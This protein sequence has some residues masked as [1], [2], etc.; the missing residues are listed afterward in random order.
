MWS[1]RADEGVGCGDR[2][3]GTFGALSC[4]CGD[5]QPAPTFN[6]GD[7]DT[8]A[9]GQQL[10]HVVEKFLTEHAAVI[11][12]IIGITENK[13]QIVDVKFT[14]A[15]SICHNLLGINDA[16]FLSNFPAR[17]ARKADC[18]AAN[19]TA[20]DLDFRNRS[21]RRRSQ[22]KCR[23]QYGGSLFV[24]SCR[25]G[26]VL[27]APRPSKPSLQFLRGASN[28]V[29]WKESFVWGP[30]THLETRK[31]NPLNRKIVHRPVFFSRSPFAWGC[32]GVVQKCFYGT[33][34][35]VGYE[36]DHA[37]GHSP[38]E[39]LLTDR[40]SPEY[41]RVLRQQGRAWRRKTVIR[42]LVEGCRPKPALLAIG[43]V[44]P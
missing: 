17:V 14:N 9:F 19:P 12:I 15:T 31:G 30:E 13:T 25:E 35:R 29:P 26:V 18:S 21:S 27:S 8:G 40:T 16:E 1:S 34:S 24:R 33:S 5:V 44:Q 3:L 2:P 28:F 11:T 32:R 42:D 38:K 22:E 10:K 23:A 20:R 6:T 7:G 4:D 39:D 36:S 43:D 37:C 41:R